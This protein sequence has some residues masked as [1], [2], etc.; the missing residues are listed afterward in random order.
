[1]F[2][3]CGSEGTQNG[4]HRNRL[5]VVV[6]RRN[7][8]HLPVVHT[9][10]SF[11]AKTVTLRL[12]NVTCPDLTQSSGR[13]FL[14]NRQSS[15]SRI[16]LAERNHQASSRGTL[17][18]LPPQPLLLGAKPWE[19]TPQP[20]QPLQIAVNLERT[21]DEGAAQMHSRRGLND[22]GKPLRKRFART[23]EDGLRQ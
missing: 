3:L 9:V 16:P 4:G 12:N 1:M 7:F 17:V 14:S 10:I 22:R 20:L 21:G 19:K 2:P 11:S 15:A 6:Y 8:F 23:F 13:K 5:R 18:D